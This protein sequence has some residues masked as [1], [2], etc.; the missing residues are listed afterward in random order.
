MS[1]EI[2]LIF[3]CVVGGFSLFLERNLT[4]M[5]HVSGVC[6]V[7]IIAMLLSNL[8]IIPANHHLYDFFTGMPVSVALILMALGLNFKDVL[9]LPRKVTYVFLIG[10]LGTSVGGLI[11][12]ILTYPH[13]GEDALKIAAQLSASYVG[14]GENAVAIKNILQTKNELFVTAF[15]FDNIITTAWFFVTLAIAKPALNEEKQSDDGNE[16]NRF[17]GAPLFLTDF[18]ITLSIA[19]I[20]NSV[21][22]YLSPILGIHRILL[23]TSLALLIGQIPQLKRR[24]S[25]SYLMGSILFVFFFFSIGAISNFKE[26]SNIPLS[27]IIMPIVIVFTHAIFMLLASWIFKTNSLQNAVCSQ[28]LIGGPATAVAVA[29]AKRSKE[30]ITLGLILGLLGYGIGTYCGMLVFHL[31]LPICKWIWG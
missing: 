9:K 3:I 18:L 30:G 6:L 14:G 29:Q 16:I 28:S 27:I 25:L 23:M 4:W 13:L 5:A 7:I 19:F 22:E 8:G 11:A 2:L 1:A 26:I 12:A 31:A 20:T 24:V 17:D 10:A 15:A 21:S